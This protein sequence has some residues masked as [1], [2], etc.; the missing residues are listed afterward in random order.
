MKHL[1]WLAVI[2]LALA[3]NLG[4]QTPCYAENDGPVFADNTSMGGPWIAIPFTP[5]TGFTATR[6][7]VFTGEALGL[8]TLALWTHDAVNNQPGSQ[9][10]SA[11]WNST[12]T[13]NAWQGNLLSSQLALTAGQT[14]WLI[15]IPVGGA[16]ASTDT[17]A[18]GLG[19]P[20]R[21][22][23][24][25]GLTWSVL[26]QDNNHWKFRIFGLCSL[27]PIVYCT[28][29]TSSN[30]CAAT[31]FASQNPDVANSVPCQIA[32]AVVEGQRAGIIFYGLAPTTQPWCS[33]GGGSSFLCVKAPTVRTGVQNSGGVLGSCNGSLALDWNAFQAAHPGALGAPWN[34]GEKVYLQGWYRDPTSCKTT[35]L[36]NA[37]E[38][39]YQP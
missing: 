35:S 7:E 23:F 26:F 13:T 3:S 27:P 20:Y 8:N 34:V 9:L 17:S 29:G 11:V 6:L 1:A 4:A 38:L 28:A 32:V 16:Q 5:P 22:S 18:P 19:Q 12:S 37:L 10:M 15:W 33:Q 39:T 36:S 25:N 21:A 30:G 24:D 31:I 2:V 14:Y